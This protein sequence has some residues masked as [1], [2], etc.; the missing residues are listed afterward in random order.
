MIGRLA[1]LCLHGG[2]INEEREENESLAVAGE[3]MMR[4]LLLAEVS[5]LH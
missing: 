5:A 2:E 3:D 1:G 4:A